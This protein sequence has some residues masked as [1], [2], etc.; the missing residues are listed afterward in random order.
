LKSV[1]DFPLGVDVAVLAIPQAT[2]L[3]T[4]AAVRVVRE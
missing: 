3:E 2:V 1:D 4:L